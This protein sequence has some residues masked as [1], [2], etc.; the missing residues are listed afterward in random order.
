MRFDT[1]E[2]VKSWYDRTKPIL[3]KN[4]VLADDV[5]PLGERRYKWERIAKI[6]DNKYA[7]LDGSWTPI[8]YAH[9]TDAGRAF[10]TEIAGKLGTILWEKRDDGEYIH[11]RGCVN[12][13]F[14]ISRYKI[15]SYCLPWTL[16]HYDNTRQ[17]K[18]WITDTKS[19]KQYPLPKMKAVVEW[20]AHKISNYKDNSLTFKRLTDAKGET[21][22]WERIGGVS[23]LDTKLDLDRKKE[24][25][26]AMNSFYEWMSTM[27]PLIPTDWES[28][29]DFQGLMAEGLGVPSFWGGRGTE[30]VTP[31]F[32]I[33][34][35]AN[36]D[37]QYRLAF[38]ATLL[39]WMEVRVCPNK[40]NDKHKS[41]RKPDGTWSF[42]VV[43]GEPYT[44]EETAAWYVREN[45]RLK[46]SYNRYMNKLLGLF[47]TT[48]V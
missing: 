8:S 30:Q 14:S 25:K 28:H 37:N 33:Q 4:H 21:I 36:E 10:N 40:H 24:L 9:D 44:E 38:A 15:L 12:T 27:Q 11:I 22:G 1:F 41:H 43:P 26:P 34:V 32:A 13:G 23:I 45:K 16:R 31:E 20:Q 42:E 35:I 3:S 48:T 18:H 6:N 29:R 5:R 46:A 2:Q 7:I 19:G 17:G 47:K 39:R